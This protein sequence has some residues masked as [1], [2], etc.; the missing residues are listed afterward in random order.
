MYPHQSRG[1]H[2]YMY[3]V[4]RWQAL[5]KFRVKSLYRAGRP[6]SLRRRIL[7][8]PFSQDRCF[9][10]WWRTR[11]SLRRSPLAARRIVTKGFAVIL[12]LIC[13]LMVMD[14]YLF[15]YSLVLSPPASFRVVPC[16]VEDS[17]GRNAGGRYVHI[18]SG[19]AASAPVLYKSVSTETKH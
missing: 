7:P 11:R 8:F 12:D 5:I 9:I 13:M 4:S 2:S 1:K 18:L 16:A 14:V 19:H 10:A 15:S 17:L 6:F 3:T